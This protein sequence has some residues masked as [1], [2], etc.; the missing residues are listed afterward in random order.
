MMTTD[1]ILSTVIPQTDAILTI[2]AGA[3][4]AMV[5]FFAMA[6]VM[7]F[8]AA[9]ELREPGGSVRGARAERLAA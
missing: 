8:G 7:L 2:G 9:G 1:V 4:V 5:A 3:M 6:L